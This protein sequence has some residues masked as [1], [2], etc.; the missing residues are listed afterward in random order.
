MA[1]L[2]SAMADP[3]FLRSPHRLA[4]LGWPALGIGQRRHVEEGS[5]EEEEFQRTMRVH[6]PVPPT[7]PRSAMANWSHYLAELGWPALGVGQRGPREESSG[8]QERP[9]PRQE[10]PGEH[11]IEQPNIPF[12][13]ESCI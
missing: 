5:M 7:L 6:S 10:A 4:E 1:G 11:F 13:K 3:K 8:R 9:L 12:G 2:R